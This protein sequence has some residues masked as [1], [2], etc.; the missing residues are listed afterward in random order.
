M[1]A[2]RAPIAPDLG[3]LVA[4]TEPEGQAE[5]ERERG[6]DADEQRV[7]ERGGDADLIRRGD[8]PERED[9]RVGDRRDGVGIRQRASAERAADQRA[10]EAGEP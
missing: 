3:G 1:R 2:L 9:R 4:A 10:G 5:R 7:H 8:D 6:D